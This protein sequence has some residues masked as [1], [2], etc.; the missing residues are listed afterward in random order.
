MGNSVLT[1]GKVTLKAADMRNAVAIT[2]SKGGEGHRQDPGGGSCWE[3]PG[4]PGGV[5][6]P[7]GS[8]NEC[9]IS[10]THLFSHKMVIA[11]LTLCDLIYK[12]SRNLG[13]LPLPCTLPICR[14][15][16]RTYWLLPVS[17][18][19]TSTPRRHLCWAGSTFSSH[20]HSPSLS[21]PT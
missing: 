10:P 4:G 19:S 17:Q 9:F 13:I 14:G 20:Y 7:L 18:F 3:P 16:M 5:A 11:V 8:S 2:L 15:G 6:W 21:S 12:F 1:T